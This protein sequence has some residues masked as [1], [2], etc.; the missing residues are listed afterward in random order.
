LGARV[1]TTAA[2]LS[3]RFGRF[4]I[5]AAER[6]LRVDGQPPRS[7]PAHSTC[8]SRWRGTAIGWS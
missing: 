6:V 4:E 8:C 7:A 3:L 1:P 5:H 2:D